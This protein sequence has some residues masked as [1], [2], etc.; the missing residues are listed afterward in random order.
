MFHRGDMVQIETSDITGEVAATL[1]SDGAVLHRVI[2]SDAEL[3]CSPACLTL[4][5]PILADVAVDILTEIE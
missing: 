3:W 4:L 1:V 5:P 2:T